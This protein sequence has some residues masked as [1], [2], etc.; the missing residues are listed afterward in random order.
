MYSVDF[1]F[2]FCK[3]NVPQ[4]LLNVAPS[5]SDGESIFPLD[6]TVQ[7][8]LFILRRLKTKILDEMLQF[9][10]LQSKVFKTQI[11]DIFFREIIFCKSRHFKHLS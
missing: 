7:T 4:R 6:S 3:T 9:S 8:F 1:R 11:Q 5:N 10:D 2:W